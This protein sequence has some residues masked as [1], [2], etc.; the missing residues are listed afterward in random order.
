MPR[1]RNGRLGTRIGP[2][3][4]SPVDRD[5]WPPRNGRAGAGAAFDPWTV[6]PRTARA[7]GRTTLVPAEPRAPTYEVR[8]PRTGEPTRVTIPEDDERIEAAFREGR[9]RA[10]GVCAISCTN[11][12]QGYVCDLEY[13]DGRAVRLPPNPYGVALFPDSIFDGDPARDEFIATPDGWQWI[14]PGRHEFHQLSAVRK[15]HGCDMVCKLATGEAPE[16]G[17]LWCMPA[18]REAEFD[19]SPAMASG[20]RDDPGWEG[21][22]ERRRRD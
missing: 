22:G 17:G 19:E 11:S 5:Y 16:P 8:H 2:E 21:W 9:F 6:R 15:D 18:D 12:H 13:A 7:M 1:H 4:R 3:Y 10:E 20:T 14:Q